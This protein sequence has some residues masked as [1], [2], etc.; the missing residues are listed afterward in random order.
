MKKIRKD[1]KNS[2][3]QF[4]LGSD[5]DY[6]LS[7]KKSIKMKKSKTKHTNSNIM[8]NGLISPKK[9]K[10]IEDNK[11]IIVFKFNS[12]KNIHLNNSIKLDEDLSYGQLLNN[13]ENNSKLELLNKEEAKY[14][15]DINNNVALQITKN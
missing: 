5:Y 9:E 13:K 1:L 15:N 10:K 14:N 11:N 2:L 3:I 4:K 8:N 6:D 12:N 7:T